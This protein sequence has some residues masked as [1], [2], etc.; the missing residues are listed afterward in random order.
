MTFRFEVTVNIKPGLTGMRRVS[1][2][3][4]V[5][6]YVFGRTVNLVEVWNTNQSEFL[7]ITGKRLWVAKS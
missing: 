1:D 6:C 7:N 2:G 5:R 4:K 3:E